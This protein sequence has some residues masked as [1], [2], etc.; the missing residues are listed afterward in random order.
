MPMGLLRIPV[1]RYATNSYVVFCGR[2]STVVVD[3]GGDAGALLCAISGT[4][5]EAIVLTHGHADHWGALA[6]LHCATGGP[7]AAH[8]ADAALLPVTPAIEL[9]DC[10]VLRAASYDLRVH[11][12][13]GH[14]AGSVA[15]ELDRGRWLVGDAVFPDG[16]GHTDGPAEFS[17]LM[18]MLS[19][20]VFALP[21]RTWLFPGH[22]EPTSVGRERA[23]FQSFVARGWTEDT[24]GDV[25]WHRSE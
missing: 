23:A 18:Q 24:H 5:L 11:H 13:P 16:P 17:R 3:P 22:G 15:L 19:S 12:V 4:R 8:P 20:R 7:V 14:T 6:E 21:D 9:H 1:G 10:Q 25:R 2:H